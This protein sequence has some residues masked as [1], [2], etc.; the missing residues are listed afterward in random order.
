MNAPIRARNPSPATCATR[1]SHRTTILKFIRESTQ[2]RSRSC[3]IS[4]G[5]LSLAVG[6]WN[7]MR[8]YTAGWNH[9]SATYVG[10]ASLE[11]VI[12]F[13][14]GRGGLCQD[15]EAALTPYCRTMNNSLLWNLLINFLHHWPTLTPYAHFPIKTTSI[16]HYPPLHGGSTQHQ[17][18][19]TG[20]DWYAWPSNQHLS[21]GPTVLNPPLSVSLI[22]S[23]GQHV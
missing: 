3:A 16:F 7:D 23:I 6:I 20:W 5:R 19:W 9:L 18:I 2:E 10:E 11:Q 22:N 1:P 4:V 17:N 8:L 14:M 21:F 15:V 13:S 12:L